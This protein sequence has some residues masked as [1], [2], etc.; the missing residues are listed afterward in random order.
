MPIYIFIIYT[1]Y[2][3]CQAHEVHKNAVCTLLY[4]PTLCILKIKSSS[5]FVNGKKKDEVEYLR[6]GGRDGD[7][8]VKWECEVGV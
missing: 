2:L 7:G 3:L 8:S 5:G 1:T 6:G 4:I